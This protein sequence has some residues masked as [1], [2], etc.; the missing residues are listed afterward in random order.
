MKY[1]ISILAIISIF[2]IIFF[3]TIGFRELSIWE[4]LRLLRSLS[5]FIFI[6]LGFY[7]SG[8]IKYRLQERFEKYYN[9]MFDSIASLPVLIFQDKLIIKPHKTNYEAKINVEPR[10]D[11]YKVCRIDNTLVIL[12]KVYDLGIFRRHMRPIQINMANSE[13]DKLKYVLKPKIRDLFYD[14][15]DLVITF[16]RSINE[17]NKLILKDFK[18]I[19]SH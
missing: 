2:P 16:E 1:W 11:N 10:L 15:N 13:V 5:I 9:S 4:S 8:Y 3:F 17:I 14:E 6:Y 18:S 7:T 12:G 19:Y